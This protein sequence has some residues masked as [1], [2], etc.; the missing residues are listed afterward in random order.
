MASPAGTRTAASPCAS[1][2]MK[3]A[4]EPIGNAVTETAHALA[5]F[6]LPRARGEHVPQRVTEAGPS[7]HSRVTLRRWQEV[8]ANCP[9]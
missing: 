2:G 3:P 6:R 1:T 5:R 9:G 7:G 4:C 8:E